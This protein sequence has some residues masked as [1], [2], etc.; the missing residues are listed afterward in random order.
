MLKAAERKG[1]LS[2]FRWAWTLSLG[3]ASLQEWLWSSS[4]EAAPR[5]SVPQ[6]ML[7]L[8]ESHGV[9]IAT[10]GVCGTKA[11]LWCNGKAQA[12]WPLEWEEMAVAEG[13]KLN[14]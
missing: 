10:S 6:K 2:P 3:G 13:L 5:P 12:S 7:G 4:G 9:S 8:K 14:S 11:M 1:P